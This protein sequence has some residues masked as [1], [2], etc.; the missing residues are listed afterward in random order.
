MKLGGGSKDARSGEISGFFGE[1]VEIQGEIRFKDVLRLDGKGSGTFRGEG[2][3]VVGPTGQV[4]GEITVGALVV[5]GRVKGK[6]RVKERLEVHSGGR[7]EG[8][9]VLGRPGLVVHD[10][11]VVEASVQM[12]TS[13]D[14]AGPAKNAAGKPAGVASAV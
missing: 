12:G 10:G 3:M 8:E 2:E 6:I 13:K 4:E 9:V 5:S 1:G 14:E 11:G 7:V